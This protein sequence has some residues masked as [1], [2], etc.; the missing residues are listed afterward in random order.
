MSRR[1][2][3]KQRTPD[4]LVE[5]KKY[6]GIKPPPRRAYP[7]EIPDTI[8]HFYRRKPF[9]PR[10]DITI[11]EIKDIMHLST[12]EAHELVQKIKSQSYSTDFPFVTVKEFA[13][14]SKLKIWQV[15]HYFIS[16]QVYEDLRTREE[17]KGRHH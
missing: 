2:E 17:Y 14:Y 16:D 1:L 4:N 11:E 3:R 7:K 8:K 13:R 12:P 9:S 15:H 5:Y 6:W 10:L